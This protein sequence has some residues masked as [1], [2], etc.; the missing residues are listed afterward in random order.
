VTIIGTFKC[1][2]CK[3]VYYGEPSQVEFFKGDFAGNVRKDLC[4]KCLTE[5]RKWIK[6]R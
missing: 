3:G 2:R 1:D 6:G 4:W 5:F